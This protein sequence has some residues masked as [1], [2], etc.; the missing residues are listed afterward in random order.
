M[1]YTNCECLK[2]N[3][4]FLPQPKTPARP[5]RGMMGDDEHILISTFVYLF[6]HLFI[7]NFIH[8]Y[9]IR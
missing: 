2:Q 6:T 8:D 4:G 9:N 3:Q 5:F 7:E 1:P